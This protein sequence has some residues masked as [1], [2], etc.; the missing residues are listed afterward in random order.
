MRSKLLLLALGC[1]LLGPSART[2]EAFTHVVNTHP[3]T[4]QPAE[5]T[6]LIDPPGE[7]ELVES[8]LAALA[9]RVSEL[10]HDDALR[11][12]FDAYYSYKAAHPKQVRNP[13]FYFVDYGR[14]NRTPRGYVFDTEEL[15]LVEGPFIVAH[16]R[17]SSNG[18]NSV[19]VRFSNRPGSAMTSLGLYV[20]Q[21][22]YG[23]SGKS[24]G[25]H[26]TSVGLRMKGV[27]GSF[28]SAAR[29][30]GIVAHGAPYVTRSGAGRSEGCPAMEQ[31]RARRLLPKLA[32]G[33]LVFL[34][35]PRDQRWME[36]DPW[37]S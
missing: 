12:A 15:K 2:T 8:A 27:S 3:L 37:A 16:G 17:G 24:G 20:A 11:M 32:N 26:Y 9:P 19:P 36:N 33:G 7:S 23:F 10:S 35:S 31:A 1:V 22:T 6:A 25:R 13:Y 29:A 4:K 14:D 34:F 18:K 21:E 30:R 28:N 5:I